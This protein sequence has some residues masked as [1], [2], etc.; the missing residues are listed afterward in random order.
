[1]SVA[2][3]LA[4]EQRLGPLPGGRVRPSVL[5]GPGAQDYCKDKGFNI[6]HNLI[7]GTTFKTYN[8]YKRKCQKAELAAQNTSKKRK[9]EDDSCDF[10][11]L[12][13][14]GKNKSPTHIYS[15]SQSVNDLDNVTKNDAFLL[16]QNHCDYDEVAQRKKLS[17]YADSCENGISNQSVQTNVQ[18]VQGQNGLD[19]VCEIPDQKDVEE[20]VLQE[21]QDTVGAVC[22]DYQGNVAAASSSGGIWLKHPGR[23]GPVSFFV[24][25]LISLNYFIYFHDAFVS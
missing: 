23:L 9:L 2:R 18:E 4:E 17:N 5:V 21:V 19:N 24:F 20:P 15:Q 22:V 16:T 8:K 11:N 10:K 1:M 13:E 3:L 7:C 12:Q 14:G 25:F 6:S